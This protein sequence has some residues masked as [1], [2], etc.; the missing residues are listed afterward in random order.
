[1]PPTQGQGSLRPR[2]STN[3]ASAPRHLRRA[4][5]VHRARSVCGSVQALAAS[6]VLPAWCEHRP[7]GRRWQWPSI[8]PA[9]ASSRS[10]RTLGRADSRN[11]TSTKTTG[12][13]GKHVVEWASAKTPE[14]RAY[15][16]GLSIGPGQACGGRGG[17]RK[18]GSWGGRTG[19]AGAKGAHHQACRSCHHALMRIRYKR[20]KDSPRIDP[21]DA[22]FFALF[23]RTR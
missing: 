9:W 4:C 16:H 22:R 5:S 13:T 1:M 14:K 12:T 19:L 3:G 2:W 15:L 6:C 11:A 21:V 10:C 18:N 7:R 8:Q 17:S 20:K 23:E